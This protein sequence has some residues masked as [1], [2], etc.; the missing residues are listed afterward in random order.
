M[1]GQ[2]RVSGPTTP[3]L[4]AGC[5]S[6]LRL[7]RARRRCYASVRPTG[8]NSDPNRHLSAERAQRAC[9]IPPHRRPRQ[10]A[11]STR[12]GRIS[13]GVSC[14]V[15]VALH[16]TARSRRPPA[17]SLL[18]RNRHASRGPSRALRKRHVGRHGGITINREASRGASRRHHNQPLASRGRHGGVT[19]A[20]LLSG[21]SLARGSAGTAGAVR[22]RA[23]SS[24]LLAGI[25]GQR[26]CSTARGLNVDC[27]VA[28][29]RPVLDQTNWW[30]LD[31]FV[32][33]RFRRKELA[34]AG[35][36][37]TATDNWFAIAAPR[38]RTWRAGGP[39]RADG[40]C[41]PWRGGAGRARS[42]GGAGPGRAGSRRGRSRRGGVMVRV[43]GRRSVRRRP[44]YRRRR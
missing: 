1:S 32:Q 18:Q 21:D 44:G 39:W 3:D 29:P 15:A 34:W 13:D 12:D 35:C 22:T 19:V 7:P 40:Q 24:P 6:Q 37:W 8:E 2:E 28:W 26:W 27:L 16:I 33:R 10:T 36:W 11:A 4:R 43:F 30:R 31:S 14:H 25:L 42:L 38:V 9:E 20:A 41:G 5:D 23:Y 17:S